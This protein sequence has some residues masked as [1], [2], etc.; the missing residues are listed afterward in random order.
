MSIRVKYFL[1]VIIVHGLITYLVFLQLQDKK[2]LFILAEILI[3]ISLV[4]SF[5][6][7]TGFVKPLRFIANG[8][9]ALEDRDFSVRFQLTSSSE[10]NKLIQVYNSL[11]DN[12]REERVQLQEQHY[13]L[14]R[15]I[16]AYPAAI[17]ILD[18]DGNIANFNP[19]AEEIF[20]KK[21]SNVVGQAP[22]VLEHHLVGPIENL[23]VGS[24]E[25]IK[26]NG[27]ERY[28]CEVAQFLHRGF[29]RKFIL[30]QEVSK[31]ILL[32]EKKAYGKVI[33][34]MAHEVN[35]SLGATNSIVDTVKSFLEEKGGE[36]DVEMAEAL[37]LAIDRHSSLSRF[38]HNFAEVVRLPKP[39]LDW[40]D[41]V[42]LVKDVAKLMRANLE[43]KDILL[44][45]DDSG[46][47][48][49]KIRLDKKQIEQV[50]VNLIKNA[51]E[52]I[53]TSGQISLRLLKDP[54]Q[55][56]IADNGSGISPDVQEQLFTPFFST[57]KDG[58]GVGLT[59]VREIVLNHGANINLTSRED[60]WTYC[61]ITFQ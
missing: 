52:A 4:L 2:G 13:F 48:S 9:S 10:L 57:K 26:L 42:T 46:I 35:N 1:F 59:L 55:I 14:E 37:A 41:L 47:T 16:Q 31:E 60:G 61:T 25:V 49:L 43:E 45:F 40:V 44:N 36:V 53:D 19:K 51:K 5:Q 3:L 32:A 33:R 39:Q 38:M 28:K 34:M 17:I 58:Q 15:L 6:I 21:S 50:L 20:G 8:V 54:V 23:A 18:F 11:I 56:I 12:I 27:T 29:Y 22:A 7:Y 24:A 30:I